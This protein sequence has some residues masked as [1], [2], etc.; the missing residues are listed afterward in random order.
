MVQVLFRFFV[1]NQYKTEAS[2]KINNYFSDLGVGGGG[3][4]GMALQG[5]FGRY[6]CAAEIAKH[7]NAYIAIK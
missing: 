4:G 3:G 5:N 7:P 6:R 1:G 2:C